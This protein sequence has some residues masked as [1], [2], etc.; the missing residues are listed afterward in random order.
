MDQQ[1]A[2]PIEG[3]EEVTTTQATPEENAMLDKALRA[4]LEP[5]TGTDPQ[6]AQAIDKQLTASGSMPERNLANMAIPL[7]DRGEKAV[8]QQITDEDMF[9]LLAKNVID[10]LIGQSIDLGALDLNKV[11]ASQEEFLEVVFI[12]FLT[13]WYEQ[14]PDRMDSDDQA[15]LA[16]LKSARQNADAGGPKPGSAAPGQPPGQQ[17]T[18]VAQGVQ[19]ANQGYMAQAAQQ[20]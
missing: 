5:L 17:Q 14:R 20:G 4:A 3:S 15:A 7:V 9:E 12:E 1:S 16:E 10:E 13:L 2:Q 19:Q 11:G 8:G 18:P 6:A